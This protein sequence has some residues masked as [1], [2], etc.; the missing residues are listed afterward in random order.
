MDSAR[1]FNVE[2]IEDFRVALALF[3]DDA[4]SAL[5]MID[6]ELRRGVDWI[7]H[8]R[9]AHWQHES[10]K[11]ADALN[12]AKENLVRC[13]TFKAMDG[14]TPACTEEKKDVE[15]AQ[16]K[17]REAEMRMQATKHWCR[18]IA[19]EMNEFE[20]RLSQVT[21]LLDSEL[22]KALAV[23]DK[24]IKSLDSYLAVEGPRTQQPLTGATSMA[25]ASN[26]ESE[27]DAETSDAE[28]ADAEGA[29][30]S[31]ASSAASS[32]AN[33]Q[34][35]LATSSDDTASATASNTAISPNTTS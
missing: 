20:G 12:R 8:E 25:N 35:N 27:A 18:E 33:Q 7:T 6:V 24:I 26:A 11:R 30:E 10:R 2:G 34:V 19:H 21:S 23:L 14:Y 4:R 5:S 31:A 16:K 1:V 15:K 28:P 17:V 3:A 13:K 29:A 22:P 32:A 9:P